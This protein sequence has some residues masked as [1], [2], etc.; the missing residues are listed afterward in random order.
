[1]L[2]WLWIENSEV[3]LVK[4][5]VRAGPD[6]CYNS[7]CLQ[8]TTYQGDL[9]CTTHT[10]AWWWNWH[11]IICVFACMWQ[12]LH[13]TTSQ[14]ESNVRD[15]GF[16][17][18]WYSEREEL[19]HPRVEGGGGHKR[20]DSLDSLDSLGSQS[21]SI[22]SD[23]TLKGSSEGRRHVLYIYMQTHAWQDTSGIL[24]KTVRACL[25]FHTAKVDFT[26]S[27][28][29]EHVLFYYFHFCIIMQ[30]WPLMLERFMCAWIIFI[31]PELY[32]YQSHKV[33]SSLWKQMYVAI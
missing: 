25:V 7:I 18:S 26:A 16:G 22:S 28:R 32:L 15:S 30:R 2:F 10:G 5:H 19:H 8:F 1:M 9:W 6:T 31:C 11:S 23:T 13:E 14:K 3:V 21:H 20:D 24:T 29:A 27:T 12:S 4:L 17:D 33:T